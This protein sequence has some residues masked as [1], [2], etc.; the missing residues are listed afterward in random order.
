MFAKKNYPAIKFKVANA[1]KLLFKS[2]TFDL[3]TFYETIE[4]VE[5]PKKVLK[6]LRRV[7]TNKGVLILAM[8]SGSWLFRFVWFV[9]ENTKGKV[10][11]GAH[12][13][14]FSHFE[15]ES[16]IKQAGFR[17]KKKI[18]S[19]LGMEVTFVLTKV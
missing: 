16:L 7:L 17:V 11:K 12:L 9:W 6:E 8:D 15:L 13:H 4:H 1:E 10:W 3:I 18:L 2:S 14:P 19:N 5:N